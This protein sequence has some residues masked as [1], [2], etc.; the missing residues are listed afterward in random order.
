MQHP[1]HLFPRE[2]D[3]PSIVEPADPDPRDSALRRVIELAEQAER[4]ACPL[5]Q[6]LRV[7]SIAGIARGALAR[8][9]RQ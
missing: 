2:A 5:E 7:L 1:Q 9:G 4:C 8:Y 3:R 6:K